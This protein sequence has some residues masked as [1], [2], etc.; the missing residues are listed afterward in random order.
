MGPVGPEI[1]AM[2]LPKPGKYG[3]QDDL[4]KFDDWVHQLL[5]YYR[6]FK[7]TGPN[8]D[9]D[10]VLYT[11]LFLEGIASK[12][13][14]QE[15]ESPDRRTLYWSFE[16]LICGLFKCFVHEAS[17]QNAANQYNWTRFNHEKGA[18]AF[19]NDLRHCAY[20]MVQPPDDYSF[21]QKFIHGLPH[22]IIKTI[23]EARRIS[24]E[25]STIEE[26]LDEVQ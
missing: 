4:E 14:N 16:D 21:K 7:V 1:K 5:K 9:D 18:L 11:G 2:N 25:H 26:I 12:W 17:A 24:A 15:I 6:M 10:R 19:Y 22:S 13:Y 20:Q 8:Q 3:G 23:F